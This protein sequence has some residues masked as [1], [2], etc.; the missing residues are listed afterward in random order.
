MPFVNVE[1]GKSGF[2]HIAIENLRLKSLQ[3]S[4]IDSHLLYRQVSECNDD[5]AGICEP[6]QSSEY[7]SRVEV[8]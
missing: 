8:I 5:L 4:S 3:I 2:F 6:S 1:Y 7:V